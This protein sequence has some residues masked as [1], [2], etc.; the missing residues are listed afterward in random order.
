[1]G[2]VVARGRTRVRPRLTD[3]QARWRP[4][5]NEDAERNARTALETAGR[6]HT[7]VLAG[8]ALFARNCDTA[9]V[10]AD[11]VGSNTNL[12]DDLQERPLGLRGLVIKKTQQ[13][14]LGR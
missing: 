7:G 9:R 11:R 14:N 10:D 13:I 4:V 12:T 6:T 3:E 8:A 2:Q 1:M 5:G